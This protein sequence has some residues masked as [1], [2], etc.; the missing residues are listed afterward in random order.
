MSYRRLLAIISMVTLAMFVASVAAA[1]P[2]AAEIYKS[3]CASCHGADGSGQTTV[4]KAMKDID[5]SNDSFK[6]IEAI[7]RA[8]TTQERVQ[9]CYLHACLRYLLRD[10]MTNESLRERFGVTAEKIA[11]I[12]R[13]ISSA[14]K[15]G[16][17]LPA[18][19]GQG[20]KFARYIPH[21]GK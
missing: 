18:N 11:A 6:H 8:M 3:K 15:E 20:N 9:A 10:Y 2:G 17:I 4:G 7:I 1:D 16:L 12:S 19:E 21:W 5:V 13:I 14:K